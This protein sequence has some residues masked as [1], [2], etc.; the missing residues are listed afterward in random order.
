MSVA[1]D[2]AKLRRL[3][4]SIEHAQARVKELSDSR[5]EIIAD[6]LNTHGATGDTIGAAAGVSQ[7]R[8]VQIKNSVNVRREMA[9]AAAKGKGR[10][11]LK[12]AEAS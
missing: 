8:T 7:P 3:R 11:R 6:L 9:R 1:M 12:V 5:D 4:V 2:L 10:R